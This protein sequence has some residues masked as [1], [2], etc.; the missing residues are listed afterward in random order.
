MNELRSYWFLDNDTVF[1]NHGS[2]GACPKPVLE[3]QTELRELMERDPVR[4]FSRQLPPLMDTAREALGKFLNADAEE[5]VFVPNATTG[6]N[7]ALGSLQLESGDELLIT[8]HAYNATR[9]I[10][11]QVCAAFGARLSVAR[12]QFP[13]TSPES[14]IESVLGQVSSRTRYAV[15]DH[16]TS[17]TGLIF[18][19][20]Q[21][22]TRLRS[23]DVRVIVDGAHAPGMLALN[24]TELGADIYAG[25]CHKWLCAPKGVGFLH[26]PRRHQSWVRPAITSHGANVPATD[27][28]KRF[29]FQFDW[30]GTNDP[31]SALA[32]PAAIEFMRSL[33]P[34]GWKDVMDHNHELALEAK[35]LLTDTLRVARA[36]PDEMTG[37][38]V[39]L[40]LPDS[41][42]LPGGTEVSAFVIDPLQA[43]LYDDYRIQ[44]PVT[45]CPAHPR[46]IR[47]SAAVYNDLS[48]YE[49]LAK[50]LT[51]LLGPP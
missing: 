43:L 45:A 10:A 34:R 13:C 24:L 42:R 37:S 50:A 14:L 25:N 31:T 30:T 8:D 20:E 49:R 27:V 2:F 39:A 40:P 22:I 35:S 38:L 51:E 21:L 4:F 6:L 1:L 23:L 33:M 11:A 12:V 36:C 47:V 7:A 5:L 32:V 19:L 15:L 41:D 28:E 44:V 16:V 29:H 46:M 18:P 48:D 26:V 9:N 3:R 17:A